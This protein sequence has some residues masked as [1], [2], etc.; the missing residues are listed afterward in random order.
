M[1]GIALSLITTRFGMGGALRKNT[2]RSSIGRPCSY[3]VNG[4]E[5]R[6][7]IAMNAMSPL[8]LH[9]GHSTCQ[10]DDVNDSDMGTGGTKAFSLDV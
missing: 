7:S 6:E 4:S 2:A 9:L 5:R 8:T 3:N 1:T 10:T